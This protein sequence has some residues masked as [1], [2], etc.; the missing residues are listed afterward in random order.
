M[1]NAEREIQ[2]NHKPDASSIES[3]ERAERRSN[4]VDH[5]HDEQKELNELVRW[6]E[7]FRQDANALEFF[8][9]LGLP[10]K[11]CPN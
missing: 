9:R 1:V 4:K 3:N 7:F 11:K 5:V 10:G 6:Q 2:A 8:E